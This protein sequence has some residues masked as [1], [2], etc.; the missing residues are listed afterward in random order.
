MLT[1]EEFTAKAEAAAET[2]YRYVARDKGV[3]RALV[4]R[5][6]ECR[7]I[8][9][10]ISFILHEADIEVE[11]VS[12]SGEH[13]DEHRY[14]KWGK[15][16]IV[17]AMWQQFIPE[18]DADDLP[19]VY[20]GSREGLQDLA[21]LH[22]AEPWAIRLWDEEGPRRALSVQERIDAAYGEANA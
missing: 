8:S 15:T 5:L 13:I 7:P 16:I 4:H 22:G 6:P 3:D 18:S 9:A 1:L 21:E 10:T 14:L 17:D 2:A 19:K 11:M 12:R 20:I